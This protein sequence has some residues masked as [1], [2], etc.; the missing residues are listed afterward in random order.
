MRIATDG[1]YRALA[2]IGACNESGYMPERHEV[3]AWLSEPVPSSRALAAITTRIS[4]LGD[5]FGRG[6]T[7][8]HLVE[9]GWIGEGSHST[10]GLT[11]LGRAL[12]GAAERAETGE[13]EAGI[14][15]LDREDPFAYARLVRQ[16]HF[17]IFE[18]ACLSHAD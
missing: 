16:Q 10:L 11:D 15:V 6:D 7:L 12:L 1:Q 4:A 8:D 3:D 14:V 13:G 2:F 9:L 5:F 17:E 18:V